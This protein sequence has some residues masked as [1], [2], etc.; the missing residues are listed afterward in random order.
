M[1]LD[2]GR[3]RLKGGGVLGDAAD[4]VQD[5]SATKGCVPSYIASRRASSR[6]T[7]GKSAPLARAGPEPFRNGRRRY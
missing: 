1:F 4:P 5:T 3:G 2:I 7:S 6:T